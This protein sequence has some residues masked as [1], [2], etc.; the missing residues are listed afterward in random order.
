MRMHVSCIG[1]RAPHTP[2]SFV[3]EARLVFIDQ[4]QET[5]Q[6]RPDRIDPRLLDRQDWAKSTYAYDR[7]RDRVTQYQSRVETLCAVLHAAAQTPEQRTDVL[8]Q[9]SVFHG[10]ITTIIPAGYAPDRTYA[11]SDA[12]RRLNEFAIVLPTYAADVAEAHS[13]AS[14]HGDGAEVARIERTEERQLRVWFIVQRLEQRYADIERRIA[15]LESAIRERDPDALPRT[16]SEQ[17]LGERTAALNA[18]IEAVETREKLQTIQI[19]GYREPMTGQITPAYHLLRVPANVNVSFFDQRTG[20]AIASGAQEIP[21]SGGAKYYQ[22]SRAFT[23]SLD[24]AHIRARVTP[25][26][27]EAE[28]SKDDASNLIFTFSAPRPEEEHPPREEERPRREE[29]R[30]RIPEREPDHPEIAVNAITP[31]Y[32]GENRRFTLEARDHALDTTSIWVVDGGQERVMWAVGQ[33]A[34][35]DH[36]PDA[37]PGRA[38]GGR[39]LVTYPAGPDG[40]TFAIDAQGNVDVVGGNASRTMQLKF[41]RRHPEGHPQ[42][43]HR[44]QE[45][46][47]NVEVRQI[48]V[49]PRR[50]TF[51]HAESRSGTEKEF[52]IVPPNQ[53]EHATVSFPAQRMQVGLNESITDNVTGITVRR[54]AN[55]EIFV[56]GARP[57]DA[58]VR[59][60]VGHGTQDLI[61][62]EVTVERELERM[63][64]APPRPGPSLGPGFIPAPPR[65]FPGFE[66]ML[67]KRRIDQ[68]GGH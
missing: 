11:A 59:L 41:V 50:H 24:P 63:Q 65:P 23:Q 6:P 34:T 66:N 19:A 54:D 35:A 47:R 1:G 44:A 37:L 21:L 15:E 62:C 64:G 22:L 49:A 56:T 52:G 9:E 42:E 25:P 29:E 18:Q 14:F 33:G 58:P 13:R 16:L 60:W 28:I 17:I 3:R 27:R 48:D 36:S 7:V 26:G 61:P 8:I 20:R 43:G 2:T 32:T 38:D 30:P 31:M 51:T 46:L 10:L 53:T 40:V 5:P 12:R 67:E 57:T 55:G 39:W 45:L 4:P 68:A